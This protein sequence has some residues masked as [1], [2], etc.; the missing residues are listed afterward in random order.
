MRLIAVKRAALSIV[1]TLAAALPLIFY[2]L[3]QHQW[4]GIVGVIGALVLAAMG[5]TG[6]SSSLLLLSSLAVIL[7]SLWGYIYVNPG[8]TALL[9]FPLVI[10]IAIIGLHM[11]LLSSSFSRGVSPSFAASS[12]ASMFLPPPWPIFGFAWALGG[13]ITS[14]FEAFSS[15]WLPTAAYSVAYL[16]ELM[17]NGLSPGSSIPL[18][19]LS[20]YSSFIAHINQ[21]ANPF[22]ASILIAAVALYVAAPLLSMKRRYLIPLSSTVAAASISILM[23][24]AVMNA[25]DP[26]LQQLLPQLYPFLAILAASSMLGVIGAVYVMDP[27]VASMLYS[28]I[29]EL[30]DTETLRQLYEENWEG[31]IGMDKIK[32][33]LVMA[34]S[35]FAARHGVRPIHGILL[36]GPSGTGKTALGLGFAAWLG[37]RGFH[38]I[39]VRTGALMKGGPWAAAYRL[40]V[41]FRLAR[42]LQP[43]VIYIDEIDSIGR[44]RTEKDPGSY[45]LV[46]VLLQEID[47]TVSRMDKVMVIATTN[48]LE[49]LD[50]ALIRPGRLGDLKVFVQHPPPQVVMDIIQGIAAHRGVTIPPNLLSKAANILE[51]GAEAEAFVNC[52]AIKQLAGA[53]EES[54][55][56]CLAGTTTGITAY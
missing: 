36:Y 2:S 21:Y 33:E 52:I 30:P 46:S 4:I 47:G 37:L 22:T 9:L 38:V 10:P 51:T 50:P 32:S 29:A 16:V 54:M 45:R 40:Y 24:M 12:L 43:T 26:S 8:G 27:D 55:E 56:A 17:L 1:V 20:F 25:I 18:R 53:D 39:I 48:Y 11:R 35:S 23:N 34:S 28:N 41:T 31:L 49:A 42:S 3:L 6:S 13:G 44:A 15:P 19:P 5:R 7:L 14:E